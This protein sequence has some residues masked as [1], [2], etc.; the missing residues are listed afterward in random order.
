[1]RILD[2]EA[3]RAGEGEEDT[4]DTRNADETRRARNVQPLGTPEDS[5]RKQRSTVMTEGSWRGESRADRP[6]A[7]GEPDSGCTKTAKSRIFRRER[8]GRGQEAI[9]Q[10]PSSAGSWSRAPGPGL[11]FGGGGQA[12]CL[13]T[14]YGCL[15]CLCVNCSLTSTSA[16]W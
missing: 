8:R 7:C 5:E 6:S 3:E 4:W 16:R 13:A 11:G 14:S 10:R 1:M 2:Q 15:A 9:G 12:P